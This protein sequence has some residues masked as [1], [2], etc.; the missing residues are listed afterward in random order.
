MDVEKGINHKANKA[1]SEGM[2]KILAELG[3]QDSKEMFIEGIAVIFDGLQLSKS[4]IKV[5]GGKKGHIAI[6]E[7]DNVSKP[8]M[9]YHLHSLVA[10]GVLESAMFDTGNG[11]FER[12]FWLTGFGKE[13]YKMFNPVHV[14]PRT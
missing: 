10:A 8:N 14:A 4:I 2:S 9:A 1:A 11:A 5:A 12:R 3:S 13:L 7:F 6:D